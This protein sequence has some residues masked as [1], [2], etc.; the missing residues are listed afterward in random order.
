MATA[1]APL[2]PAPGYFTLDREQLTLPQPRTD[3]L[4]S[5]LNHWLRRKVLRHVNN[6]DALF[7]PSLLSDIF[8]HNLSGLD[9]HIGELVESGVL[10]EVGQRRVRGAWEHFY[11]SAVT[12]NLIVHAVLKGTVEADN[13]AEAD[14][15]A[16]STAS[17][18]K[19]GRKKGKRKK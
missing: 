14:Y 15:R 2:A 19:K 7:S 13:E 6:V 18:P 8:D 9:Y 5:S 10:F 1:T 4:V 12:D 3:E 16:K 11:V 17:K